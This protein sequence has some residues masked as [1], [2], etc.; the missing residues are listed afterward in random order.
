MIQCAETSEKGNDCLR[1][2]AAPA[3]SG[4]KLFITGKRVARGSVIIDSAEGA[5]C[6]RSMVIP[7]ARCVKCKRWARVLPL[8][9]LPRKT[10]GIDVIE[11]GVGRY[12]G[13]ITSYRETAA[14]ITVVDAPSPAHST[15]HRWI[16]GLGEKVLD[17]RPA[18]RDK[19][20]P[21]SS[22]VM[23]QSERTLATDVVDPYQN[24]TVLMA[25]SKYRSEH[26][27]DQLAAVARLLL[28]A[29]MLFSVV[30]CSLQKWNGLLLPSF[31]VAVWDFPSGF[32]GTPMQRVH[33]P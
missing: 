1:L 16:T 21:T 27:Y 12:L 28:V 20:P 31:F 25:P 8:E 33:P 6:Y 18:I 22:A 32:Q 15:L 19:Y 7:L 4:N 2:A 24:A 26:R 29:S 9:L 10:Y 30:R 14:G 3:C 11:L 5:V 17:R 13:G 23:A